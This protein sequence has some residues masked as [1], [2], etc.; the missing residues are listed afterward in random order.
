[1]ATASPK[2]SSLK[3]LVSSILGT[4][5]NA[6]VMLVT[7]KEPGGGR[8]ALKIVKR[9]EPEDD[10]DVE[11]L[12]AEYEASGKLNSPSILK[13]FD[14][15]A[16]RSWTFQVIRGELLMEYVDGKPLSAFDDPM[17]IDAG[18][19]LFLKVAGALAHMHRRGVFHGDLRPSKILLGRN[20][21]VKVRGYG[22]SLVDAKLLVQF[23]PNRNYAS[24]EQSKEKLLDEKTEIYALG[25]TFYHIFTGLAPGGVMGRTEGRKLAIPSSVNPRIPSA[26][27]NLLVTCLQSNPH[28]R[29]ATL[30]DVKIQLEELSKSLAVDEDALA[31]LAVREE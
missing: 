14:F 17:P 30:E 12:R 26:L 11:R 24:P 22:L 13:A 10:L 8:Y 25:A 5:G 20:G 21:S 16:K 7:D 6:T 31:G 23:K 27:N 19:L 28:K 29:P 4:D 18:V 2:L 1:M 3:Y 9:E 15:C